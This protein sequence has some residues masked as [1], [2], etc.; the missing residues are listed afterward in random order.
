MDWRDV[1]TTSGGISSIAWMRGIEDADHASIV[2]SFI[3]DQPLYGQSVILKLRADDSNVLFTD[4]SLLAILRLAV[5]AATKSA[6]LTNR[7][8]RDI[9]TRA[10]LMANQ[11]IHVE[12][13]P[14]VRT[15]GPQDL[16][17]SEVR[18][19]SSILENPHV[20]LARTAAFFEWSKRPRRTTSSC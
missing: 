18:S 6:Q 19:K 13:N 11:L 9:F 5:V 7:E 16:M 3:R 14:P 2:E 20:L 8:F 10:V 4:E 1:V 17:A 15:G 12:I